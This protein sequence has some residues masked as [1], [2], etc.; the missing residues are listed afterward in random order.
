VNQQA[1]GLVV[2]LEGISPEGEPTGRSPVAN[3]KGDSLS[4]NHRM[5]IR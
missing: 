3:A 5:E 4:E 2:N 1:E